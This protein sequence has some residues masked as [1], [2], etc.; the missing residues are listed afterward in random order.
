MLGAMPPTTR[1][2]MSGSYTLERGFCRLCPKGDLRL[3]KLLVRLYSSLRCA[4]RGSGFIFCFLCGVFKRS[5]EFGV[6][7]SSVLVESS[8]PSPEI[9]QCQTATPWPD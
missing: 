5:R 7:W 1:A 9:K 3:S 2:L 6:V 8:D 4:A